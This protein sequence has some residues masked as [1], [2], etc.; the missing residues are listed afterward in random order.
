MIF[1]NK[2]LSSSNTTRQSTNIRGFTHKLHCACI[3][4]STQISE[5]WWK[6]AL[7]SGVNK[8]GKKVQPSP[9]NVIVFHKDFVCWASWSCAWRRWLKMCTAAQV[10]ERIGDT[11]CAQISQN[12]DLGRATVVAVCKCVHLPPLHPSQILETPGYW[13]PYSSCIA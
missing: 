8:S 11:G 3:Y 6:R 7:S 5:I 2:S 4:Y 10:S 13:Y 1:C 9:A 12:C